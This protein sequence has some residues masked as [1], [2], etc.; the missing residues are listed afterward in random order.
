MEKAKKLASDATGDPAAAKAQ[1]KFF[2]R[3]LEDRETHLCIDC[4]MDKEMPW[5]N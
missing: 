5:K 3:S 1:A 4:S 2:F